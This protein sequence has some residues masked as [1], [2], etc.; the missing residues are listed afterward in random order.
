MARFI[1][2][3]QAPDGSSVYLCDENGSLICASTDLE[4]D[5]NELAEYVNRLVKGIQEGAPADYDVSIRDLDGQARGVY[6]APVEIG[7]IDTG[8]MVYLTTP[9][10]TILH[11]LNRF[12]TL[13][14]LLVAPCAL[15]LLALAWRSWTAGEQARRSD[16][17][18]R[19]LSNRY[20]AVYRVNF[21]TDTYEMAK[22]SEYVSQRLPPKG[23]Y[24]ELL[25]VIGEVIEPEA[26][27]EFA[28]SFSSAKIRKLADKRLQEFGEDF[29]RRF[30]EEYRWVSAR[31]L[32]DE[33]L[34]SD[35]V[36]L[37]FREIDAE[38]HQQF[39]ERKL[40][41]EALASAKRSE[42]AKQTFFSNMSH[43]MRTPLNAIQNLSAL[44]LEHV[45]QAEKCQSY[46][47]KIAY[48]SRQLLGLVNDILDISR[49]EQR[50]VVLD[51]QRLDLARCVQNCASPFQLQ[52]EAEQK[53]FVV[54]CDLKDRYVLGNAA[55]IDQIL[56]N[57]LSNAFKFT[58]PGD[59]IFLG[60]H[61]VNGMERSQYQFVIQDSGIGMSED[62]LPKLFEP[63]ARETRFSQRKTPGT[64]LGMPLVKNLVT[65]MSGQIRVESHPGEGSV[66]TIT[67]PFFILD[68]EPGSEP[69]QHDQPQPSPGALAGKKLLVAEDNMLNME[70]ATEV[71]S[72]EGIETVQA[73][74]GREAVEHFS[75]SAPYEID[76]ILMDMQM[77]EMDGCEAA[78]AIRALARPD[79][80]T[81]PIIA[82]TA[83]AFAE[84]IAATTAAGM[85]AHVSKPIDFKLLCH[86][87]SQLTGAEG[88]LH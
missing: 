57:L 14:A 24:P 46:L 16:D 55:R 44:A 85:N 82:V 35:E 11:P 84:D 73:W 5:S 18:A 64:G 59:R 72:M 67:I 22:G 37:I 34:R 1:D 56:N 3:V 78:R 9:F 43:D 66:F 38:K 28:D 21:I 54:E 71:L 4:I 40:L 51:N 30:G 25:R 36:V 39:Q 70:I 19:A 33:T 68:P 69:V 17:I 65:E 27:R 88:K 50:K 29:L 13:F 15:A 79:A 74:N 60:V 76:A 10:D 7:K 75:A 53:Q 26:F 48:S 87:L 80:K 47:E 49:M 32:F 20:Y 2:R 61:Q 12:S 42:K 41:Q 52:A 77:P 83:N 62:F 45:D 8:W 63:Y 6:A 81:V 58:E 23:P 86:T 31:V